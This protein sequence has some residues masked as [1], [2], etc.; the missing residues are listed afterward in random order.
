MLR[1][2][3]ICLLALP[4]APAVLWAASVELEDGRVLHGELRSDK[5]ADPLVIRVQQAGMTA[6]M[7]IPQGQVRHIDSSPDPQQQAMARVRRQF[8]AASADP[9]ASPENRW[10]VAQ[11]FTEYEAM[12]E[13]RTAARAIIRDFP[14]FAPAREILGH[15]LV[16]GEWLDFAE[17]RQAEGLEWYDGQWRDAAEAERLR[18]LAQAERQERQRQADLRRVQRRWAAEDRR[19]RWHEPATRIPVVNVVGQSTR[20]CPWGTPVRHQH[21]R[22]HSVSVSHGS[23]FV[24]FGSVRWSHSR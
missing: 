23:G 3:C 18:A 14:D 10:Q 16:D 4:A 15:E 12:A 2:L 9:A 5:D 13:L 11:G 1:I 6:E 24:T 20:H 22:H 19:R 8:A 17:A 21:H 7:R